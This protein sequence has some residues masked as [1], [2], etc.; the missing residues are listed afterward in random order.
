M[1]YVHSLKSLNN[2]AIGLQICLEIQ[3]QISPKKKFICILL[4]T[5]S[6]TNIGLLQWTR[7]IIRTISFYP[8]IYKVTRVMYNSTFSPIRL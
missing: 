6:K 2:P 5:F 1:Y 3:Q 4:W 7:H 8:D